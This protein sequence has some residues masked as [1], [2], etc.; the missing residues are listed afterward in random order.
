MI[1]SGVVSY[2]AMQVSSTHLNGTL[3]GLKRFAEEGMKLPFEIVGIWHRILPL[4]CR[5]AGYPITPNARE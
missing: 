2:P 1:V 3:V 5:V 4:I